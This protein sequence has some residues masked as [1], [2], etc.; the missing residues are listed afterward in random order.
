MLNALRLID[1][2]DKSLF[3]ERCGLPFQILDKPL[4]S[5]LKLGLINETISH[6]KPTT[7]GL[8]FHN[9]LQALFLD[10]ETN[11]QHRIEPKIDF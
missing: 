3:S 5:A 4:Q 10:I 9:D 8:Q 6:L 2:F 11:D 1:G 7:L